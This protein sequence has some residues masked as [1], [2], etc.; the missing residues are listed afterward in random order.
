MLMSLIICT[1]NR[2]PQLKECLKEIASASIPQC[3]LEVVLVD[4][5]SDDSTNKIITEFMDTSSLKVTHVNCK[6]IGSA[7]ARNCGISASKGKW[8]LFTD[9][10]CYIENNFFRNFFDFVKNTLTS[11]EKLKEIKYGSGPIIPYDNQHD[12]RVANLA[13]TTINLIPRN[14]LLPAGIVQ[15]ANMFF[16]RSVFDRVGY[17]NE[18]MGTGTPFVAADIEMATRSS[19]AGFLGAQVPFFKVIHHH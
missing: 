16:H 2:A 13:I 15:G 6:Q 3:D 9:D 1:R 7:F 19:L 14:I 10:D 12:P 11:N 18:R 4:N 17:F 5:A 8:L